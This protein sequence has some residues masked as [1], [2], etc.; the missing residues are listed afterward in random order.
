M[1]LEGFTS[2]SLEHAAGNGMTVP[3]VGFAMLTAVL[4]LEKKI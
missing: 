3:C 2:S 1:N 4:A